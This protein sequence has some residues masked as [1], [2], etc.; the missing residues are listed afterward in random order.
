MAARAHASRT[1]RPRRKEYRGSQAAHNEP[2]QGMYGLEAT[3]PQYP[4]TV[5][6]LG[7]VAAV[8]LGQDGQA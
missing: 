7:E 1:G 6:W 2:T 3:H 4:Q 8:L 5:L